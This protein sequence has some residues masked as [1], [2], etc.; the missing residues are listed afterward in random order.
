MARLYPINQRVSITDA[1]G[2]LIEFRPAD[3]QSLIIQVITGSSPI[4]IGD[5]GHTTY[6]TGYPMVAGDVFSLSWEDFTHE[7]RESLDLVQLWAICNTGL[8]ATVQVYGWLRQ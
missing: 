3:L 8:T 1:A 4:A 6:A 2:L 7:E 5:E